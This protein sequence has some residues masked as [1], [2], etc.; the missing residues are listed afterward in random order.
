MWDPLISGFIKQVHVF[1]FFLF[2]LSPLTLAMVVAATQETPKR[3]QDDG[4]LRH[5]R[6]CQPHK[7]G[8]CDGQVQCRSGSLGQTSGGEEVETN[9]WRRKKC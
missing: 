4:H 8:D 1:F 7:S 3:A 6:R 5:L 2:I 9:G